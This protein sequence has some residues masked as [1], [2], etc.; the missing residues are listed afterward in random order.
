MRPLL[1][2][3]CSVVAA[4]AAALRIVPAEAALRTT[5]QFVAIATLADGTE[6]DVTGE[7]EWRVSKP[8]LARL[9]STARIVALADGTLAVSAAYQGERASAT[10]RI[11]G[12]QAARSASFTRDI[13]AIFTRRGCN[14]AACHGSVKGAGGFKLSANGLYPRDDYDWIVKGGGYQVL[15]TEVKG[16]RIPRV[17]LKSPESSLLIEKPS[18]VKPH[19]G[20]LRLE[21]DSDD[22]RTIAQWVRAGAPFGGEREPKLAG[23]AVFPPTGAVPAGAGYRLLVTA[24]FDDGHTEDF[25][26]EVMYS[27]NNSDVAAVSP[28]G[29]VSARRL[30]ET[31]ILIRAA[32]Q[33]SSATVGVVG[34]PVAAWPQI[35]QSNFIDGFVFAKLKRFHIVPSDLAGDAEFLRRVCLD[36]T[37]TLAPP[38]RVREF[39]AGRDPAKRDNIIDALIASPEFVDYWT[40]RF[41]DIFRVAIFANGLTPKWSQ[42]YWEWIRAN[43]E[44]NRPYDEVARERISAQGYDAASRHFLPYNQI[45]PPADVMAEEVRVFFGRRM[46]CA[47]CHNHPYENWSQDQF[48]G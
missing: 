47:Q 7:A 42:K 30:G 19:G 33:I 38:E 24:R 45:G 28:A 26:H 5:Q 25:T 17:D 46:D 36:L 22:Y 31:A 35:P 43:I 20:G 11:R 39:V 6:R 12:A 34:P 2:F 18:M 3:L 4:R 37:G 32:G 23:L 15:T 8:E 40:F 10:V 21:K 14:S 9:A 27:S 41:S 48:W 13:E 29:E 44:T 16:D 1:L